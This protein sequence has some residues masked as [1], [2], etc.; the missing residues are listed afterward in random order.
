MYFVYVLYSENFDKIY[1]GFSQDLE[2]RMLFHNEL[3]IK[4]WTLSFRPWTLIYS[5]EYQTKSEALVRE[6]QLKSS[7]GRKF[8]RELIRN[9]G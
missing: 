3:S 2:R 1:I 5:E 7:K 8:I 6:K 9:K 4:G